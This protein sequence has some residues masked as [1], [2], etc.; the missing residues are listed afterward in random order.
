MSIE[1]E[2]REQLRGAWAAWL[3]ERDKPWDAFITVTFRK[4]REARHAISTLNGIKRTLD[5]AVETSAGFLGTEPHMSQAIHVHGLVSWNEPAALS[6]IRTIT[7]RRLFKAYGRSQV[8]EPKSIGGVAGYVAK[9]VLK[10][11]GEYVVW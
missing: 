5:G 3:T 9:Y 11:L 8:V 1:W 4:P 10:S 7:W 2:E 6:I